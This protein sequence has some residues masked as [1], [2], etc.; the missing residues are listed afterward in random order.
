MTTFTVPFSRCDFEL[1]FEANAQE[2]SFELQVITNDDE[3][4]QEL[5]L[6]QQQ[7][8]EK[9]LQQI[10]QG[11]AQITNS[12][13]T[14]QQEIGNVAMDFAENFVRVIFENNPELAVE[15]IKAQLES[16]FSKFEVPTKTDVFVHPEFI[17]VISEKFQ[18]SEFP[19][20]EFHPD[21]LLEKSDCRIEGPDSGWI[22]R[23]ENQLELARDRLFET[24]GGD[25]S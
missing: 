7:Q 20:L 24:M 17:Q 21:P 18:S 15:K 13:K 6:Q 16:A 22:A 2:L 12:V 25:E 19:E 10:Q 8:I 4:K 23:I 9:L 14:Q 1:G 3:V 11:F 5:L